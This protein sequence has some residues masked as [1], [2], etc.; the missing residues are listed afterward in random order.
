MRFQTPL[1]PCDLSLIAQTVVLRVSVWSDS[2]YNAVN[3]TNNQANN[4]TNCLKDIKS[5]EQHRNSQSSITA[6]CKHLL[7]IKKQHTRKYYFGAVEA[8]TVAVAQCA[9]LDMAYTRQQ[10]ARNAFTV[11]RV[12]VVSEFYQLYCLLLNFYV[13]M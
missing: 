6:S 13:C 2:S 11:K 5:Y 12:L 4:S 8:A 9:H 7:N 1:R 10:P 3:T